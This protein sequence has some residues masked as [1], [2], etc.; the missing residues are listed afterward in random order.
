MAETDQ[1]DRALE[2]LEAFSDATKSSIEGL[3]QV[4]AQLQGAKRRR[5][6]GWSWRRIVAED[7]MLKALSSVVALT[8][9]ISRSGGRF[10]RAL[11]AVLRRE[12]A[13]TTELADLMGVTRQ[14]VSALSRSEPD[15]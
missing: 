14:R 4:Q 13:T 2:A 10:R 9:D 8:A 6:R 3:T 12:G 5:R 11:A 15:D 7:G 1:H